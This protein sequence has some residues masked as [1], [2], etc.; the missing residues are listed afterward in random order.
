MVVIY[1]SSRLWKLDCC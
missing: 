1:G